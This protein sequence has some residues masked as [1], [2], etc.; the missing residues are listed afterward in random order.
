MILLSPAT[1]NDDAFLLGMR[2]DPELMAF[3]DSQQ[4]AGP[5][6]LNGHLDVIYAPVGFVRRDIHADG[7]VEVSI[8]ILRGMRGRGIGPEALRTL[9][10]T[11]TA[12][13][14]LRARVKTSNPASQRAFEKAGFKATRAT[15]EH[16]IYEVG[17]G[18]CS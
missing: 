1:P 10:A 16:I 13:G 18:K 9:L 17:G 5:S 12:S 6:W 7:S 15:T 11:R 14:P 8:A 2:N 3:G 4:R